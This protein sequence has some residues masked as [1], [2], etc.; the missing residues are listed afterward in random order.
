MD[1]ISF[2]KTVRYEARRLPEVNVSNIDPRIYDKNRTVVFDNTEGTCKIAPVEYLPKKSWKIQYIKYFSKL[3]EV[4][5][6]FK[7]II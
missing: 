6:S 1:A 3:R 2:L 7:Y 5:I 4:K